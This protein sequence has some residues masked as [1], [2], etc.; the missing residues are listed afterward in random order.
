MAAETGAI[1]DRAAAL[2]AQIDALPAD[3]FQFDARMPD[4]WLADRYFVR[5]AL[6]LEYAGR[7]PIVTMQVFNKRGGVLAGI[8]EVV[9][10]LQTQLADGYTATQLTIDTLIEGDVFEAWDTV[11][12]IRGP[13]RAFAHLETAYL[14]VLSRRS[15]VATRTRAVVTAAAGKPVIFM[16]ARHDDWRVQVADGYAAMVGGAES[17]ST[18]AN[19]AWWGA[20][21]AGT[22]PHALIAAMG[23]DTVAATLAFARYVRAREPEVKVISLVDYDNDVIHTSLAVARAMAA[24][25]GPGVLDGLRIDTSEKLIDRSLI[26]DPTAWGRETLTG[27][28]P[29]LVRRLRA[30]LDDAG[31]GTV[32]IVVSG[33]FDEAKIEEFERLDVPVAAYGVGSD[34]IQGNY[35]F[36]A[37]IVRVDDQDT[38]KV[39]RRYERNGRMV[40]VDWERVRSDQSPEQ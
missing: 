9:R 12:H 20:R 21:G 16:P 17:V 36:T 38:A 29:Q 30:A 4:G 14:G 1:P 34:L 15:R 5:A 13:Y 35:D 25:F 8:P 37:D 2:H 31:F 32:G 10:M 22:M 24:E 26:G 11:M 33:G 40:R 19:G 28:N 23:G 18:D 6:T 39:G 3:V 27:V 7:D